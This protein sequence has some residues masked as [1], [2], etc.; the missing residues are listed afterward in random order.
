MAK[1]DRKKAPPIKEPVDFDIVLPGCDKHTLS[2]GVEVYALN[3]GAEDTLLINWVFFSGN[4]YDQQKLQAS[5]TNFLIKNG[6]SNRNA[7][8]LNE[9]F[10]YY[11]AYVNRSC[12]SE[13]ADIT[14]HCLSKHAKELLPVVAEMVVDSV[15]REE[16]LAIFI[17]NSKQRLTVGLQK[18]DFVAGRLI[19]A[20]L[21]G[22]KHPYGVYSNM[23][24]YTN[25]KREDLLSFFD[26]YYR[27]GRCVM[28]VAGKIPDGFINQLEEN[29]GK[30][31]LRPHHSPEA[32]LIHQLQPAQQ[33]KIAVLNDPDGVQAAIRIARPFPSRHHP[34]FQKAMVLNNV[35]GGFFGARLSANIR[36]DK[37]YTYGIYSYLMNQVKESGWMVSTEAGREVAQATIDEVY[38]EMELL[39]NELVDDEEL[40]MIRNYMIGTV[41]GDLDGPFQVIGR[42]KSLLLNGLD[43]AY[44]Y[45]GI[46]IARTITAKELQELANKY[47]VP[48]DFYEL[49]VI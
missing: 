1:T 47:L 49:T 26:K 33:K 45:R 46:E 37:G 6:T 29:F 32:E 15:Y 34:D 35:F 27:N 23:E 39:R 14:I 11:G 13:T 43:E 9:H 40:Q 44:F 24:D 7:F 28:F 38:K 25:L 12:Y 17:Q 30:L 2:N 41:L 10:E 19:D 21:F 3:M 8:Q 4:W 20:Y 5:A 22:E 36:E 42:W 48:E 18:N 16:E 31:P